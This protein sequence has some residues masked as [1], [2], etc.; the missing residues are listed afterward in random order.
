MKIALVTDELH[1]INKIVV[2]WL[3]EHAFDPVLFGAYKTGVDSPW[4]EVTAE[5]ACAVADGDCDEGIFF[6]WSGTGAS[7]AANKIRGIR[8]A[9]CADAETAHLA[10]VWNHANVLVLS[11]RSLTK[12]I[13]QKILEVWFK[14]YD[15][16]KG[17]SGV[18][19]LKLLE[20]TNT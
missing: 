14:P 1:P 5:A 17:A 6:C 16:E 4:V 13:A 8:A 7:I 2:E 10:R 3:K 12:Q 19:A 18:T 20:E 9:L 11:N 15:Q